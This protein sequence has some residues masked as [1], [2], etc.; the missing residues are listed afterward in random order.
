M[1]TTELNYW[2]AVYS[3]EYYIEHPEQRLEDDIKFTEK[4]G[5]T[6]KE[7]EQNIANFKKHLK[8]RSK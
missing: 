8:N 6:E 1:P 4:Y 3:E 7:C 5:M 2:Y